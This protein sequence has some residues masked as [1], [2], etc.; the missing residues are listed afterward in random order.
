[1]TE[2]QETAAAKRKAIKAT[3]LRQMGS[4]GPSE[5]E[6]YD[7][8][9][10]EAAEMS[11][12]D[13]VRV[14]RSLAFAAACEKE[15]VESAK[16]RESTLRYRLGVAYR[17]AIAAGVSGVDMAGDHIPVWLL[18]SSG[19]FAKRWDSQDAMAVDLGATPAGEPQPWWEQVIKGELWGQDQ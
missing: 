10:A 17:Q 12:A 2:D 7:P 11:P 5:G 13:H 9:V 19:H 15:A 3:L 8:E 16:R 6:G 1:M 14:V 18:T 4:C